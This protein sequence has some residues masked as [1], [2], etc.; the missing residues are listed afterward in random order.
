MSIILNNLPYPIYKRIFEYNNQ[1]DLR[2]ICLINIHIYKYSLALL[3]HIFSFENINEINKDYHKK[4]TIKLRD[5][6]LESIPDSICQITSL[7]KLDLSCNRITL[8]SENICQMAIRII[9]SIILT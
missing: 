5:R 8:I 1:K 6:R 3:E 7:Q 2:Y 9:I 4:I